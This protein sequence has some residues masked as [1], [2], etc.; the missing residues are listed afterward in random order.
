MQYRVFGFRSGT[1][2][3]GRLEIALS[4]HNATIPAKSREEIMEGFGVGSSGFF[5]LEDKFGQEFENYVVLNDEAVKGCK[6]L[7]FTTGT[8]LGVVD[9]EEIRPILLPLFNKSIWS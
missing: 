7:G 9:I 3:N 2:D 1:F 6:T 5:Y 4:K 8:Y